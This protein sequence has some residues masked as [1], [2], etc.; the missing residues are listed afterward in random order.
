MK[1]K[2]VFT[3]SEGGGNL[4]TTNPIGTIPK[5]GMI[6]ILRCYRAFVPGLYVGEKV[7]F[8]F[9]ECDRC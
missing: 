3:S 4:S 8:G 1:F 5:S 6:A 9:L 7:K 2:I